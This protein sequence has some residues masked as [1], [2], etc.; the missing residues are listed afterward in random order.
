M[1]IKVKIILIFLTFL[2]ETTSAQLGQYTLDLNEKS[3]EG[4]FVTLYQME[5]YAKTSSWLEFNGTI[6]EEKWPQGLFS[7]TFCHRYPRIYQTYSIQK[8]FTKYYY[9]FEM[10]YLRPRNYLFTYAVNDEDTN[11]LYSEYHLGRKAFRLCKKGTKY[12]AWHRE[13][14]DFKKWTSA[15]A[16]TS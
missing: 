15:C 2:M 6:D 10:N 11:E 7:F 4:I 16:V 9:R 1:R 8:L 14:P 3:S 5:G 12:C 13:M